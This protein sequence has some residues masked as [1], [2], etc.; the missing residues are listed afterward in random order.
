MNNDRYIAVVA[1]LNMLQNDVSG[2]EQM[3]AEEEGCAMEL[4]LIEGVYKRLE[5]IGV[6]LERGATED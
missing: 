4:E 6:L 5:R 2:L 1:K 3:I